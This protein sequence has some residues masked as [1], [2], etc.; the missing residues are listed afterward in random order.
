V[1]SESQPNTRLS[2]QANHRVTPK[3]VCHLMASHQLQGRH[4]G[5]MQ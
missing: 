5:C 1:R 3:G 4:L 2:E